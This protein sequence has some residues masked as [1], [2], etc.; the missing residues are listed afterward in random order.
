MVGIDEKWIAFASLA[1]RVVEIVP[2][3]SEVD[4]IIS[5]SRNL[6]ATKATGFG[7]KLFMVRV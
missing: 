7:E 4:R 3:E 5:I 2:P 6:M 1:E